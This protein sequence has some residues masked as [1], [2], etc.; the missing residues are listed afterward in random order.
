MTEANVTTM[1]EREEHDLARRLA[2]GS[3]VFG[4]DTAL[5]IVKLRPERAREIL[6]MREEMAR[7]QAE[8]RRGRERRRRALIEDYG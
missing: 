5:E 3:E 8:R 6:R 2:E 4:F 7:A 1:D